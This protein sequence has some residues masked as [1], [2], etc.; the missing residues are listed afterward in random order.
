[1]SEDQSE[2]RTSAD[3]RGAF[4]DYQSGG[5]SP[6]PQRAAPPDSGGP[7]GSADHQPGKVEASAEPEGPGALRPPRQ[8][9]DSGS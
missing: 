5:E 1:M 3:P 6:A 9:P 7:T 8:E 2:A 4:G